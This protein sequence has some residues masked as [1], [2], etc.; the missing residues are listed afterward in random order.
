MVIVTANHDAKVQQCM[1]CVTGPKS[2][3][4]L[5]TIFMECNNLY[6]AEKNSGNFCFNAIV[7]KCIT[8][9]ITFFALR[10]SESIYGKPRAEEI[11]ERKSDVIIFKED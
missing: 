2:N 8:G 6:C 10:H 3:L 4:F 5:E 9:T 7:I 11:W 1:Y